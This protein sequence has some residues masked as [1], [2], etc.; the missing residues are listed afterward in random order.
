MKTKY[1]IANAIVALF[2]ALSPITSHAYFTTAQT[3]NALTENAGL[4]SVSYRFGALKQD[5]YM[6]TTP[7]RN[8]LTDTADNRLGYTI[9]TDQDDISDVGIAT[10]VIKSSAEVRDGYYF[11]PAGTAST[12]ELIVVLQT[13]PYAREMDYYLQVESLPFKA[14]LETG[15]QDRRLNP[16][17]LQ[18]Y[19]TP[20]IELNEETSP[21]GLKISL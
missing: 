17:E 12:F 20:E 5:F 4:F 18:Y 10:A 3:A 1:I 15:L 6:P 14:Q 7:I 16:S 9:R 13:D 8:I 21:V 19:A 11:I 2:I